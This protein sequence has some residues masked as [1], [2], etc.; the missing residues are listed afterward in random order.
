V[1]LDRVAMPVQDAYSAKTYANNVM[2]LWCV[3]R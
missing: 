3:G 2:S 1:R